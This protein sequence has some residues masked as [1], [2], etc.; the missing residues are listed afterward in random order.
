MATWSSVVPT[1]TRSDEG[2]IA[3][4]FCHEPCTVGSCRDG[5]YLVRIVI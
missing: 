5:T 4:N 1:A 2:E 3:V